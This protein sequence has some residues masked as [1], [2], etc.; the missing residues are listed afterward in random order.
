M[1]LI[2][3]CG[4]SGCVIARKL[5]EKNEK[6]LIIEKRDHIGGNCY[7][8]I[9]KDTN[10][11]VNKYGPHFF[12][13]NDEKV[14]KY[15]NKYEKWERY[16]HTVLGYIDNKYVTIPVNISTVNKL[17]NEN[18]Q[19]EKEMDE[20]LKKNQVKYDEIKNGEEMAKS[21]VG[22]VLYEKVFK[23]Y[24]YKQWNKFPNSLKPEV[25]ARIPVRNNQ[26][27]RYFSDKYQV[28]P[29][30]G[31][32]KFFEN[33]LDHPLIETKLNT[34]YFQFRKE[35][36]LNT[37]KGIIY[38]GPIDHYFSS[39]GYEKLQYRS[40]KFV[41]ERHFNMNYYQPSAQV[42]YPGLDKKFTRI[43]EYKHCLNQKSKHT[44]ISK[45]YGC[46]DGEPYYPVLT[47]RNLQLYEKYKKLSDNLKKKNIHFI[48]RLANY[49]YFNM[50]QAI[51]NALDYFKD[52]L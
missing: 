43:T 12:H 8:Y 7:D 1:Y 29:K 24:T 19:T 14:W 48:G 2:V 38:T 44:I 47:E 27:T 32:T 5:A 26:D 23:N 20:W 30:N 35:N 13:T 33:I 6:V 16:E 51:K 45:E 46:D 4:L 17:C 9:D 34:D 50:D 37:F 11:L 22:E 28:L 40:I 3:G 21:R 31:Y 42:N 36:N 15:I 41:F 25:L 10:I 49:K 39:E 52:N 18:I